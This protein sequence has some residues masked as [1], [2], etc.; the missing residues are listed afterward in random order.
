MFEKIEI[1]GGHFEKCNFGGKK[2]PKYR[3]RDVFAREN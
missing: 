3:G 2:R 1:S